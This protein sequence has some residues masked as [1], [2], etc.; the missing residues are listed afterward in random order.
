M[1]GVHQ[2]RTGHLFFRESFMRQILI[3]L[4]SV[5]LLGIGIIGLLFGC[6][7]FADGPIADGKPPTAGQIFGLLIPLALLFGSYFLSKS[8]KKVSNKGSAK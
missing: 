6:L 3:K 1:H 7:F 4:A 2:A 8:S 5:L